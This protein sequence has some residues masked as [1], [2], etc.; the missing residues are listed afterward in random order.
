MTGRIQLVSPRT[1]AEVCADARLVSC[2]H[3]SRMPGLPCVTHPGNGANGHHLTRFARA[4]RSGLISN[5]ELR[6]IFYVEAV[7]RNTT[8]IYEP[9]AQS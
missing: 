7:F 4:W 9:A 2:G 5:D 8:V 3:C 6:A 1:L